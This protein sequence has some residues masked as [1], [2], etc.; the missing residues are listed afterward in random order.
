MRNSTLARAIAWTLALLLLPDVAAAREPAAPTTS[1]EQNGFVLRSA[2]GA[3]S[4]RLLGLLQIQLAHEQTAGSPG[5]G[6]LFVNRARAGLLG[7]I[8]SRDLRYTL[9]AEFSGKSPRLMFLNVDYTFVPD[10]LSLR[11]GQFKR[12]FSRPFMTLASELSMIDRPSPVGPAVFGDNADIGVMLHNGTTGRLEYA[13]GIFNGA[14]PNVLP[15][16]VHP[17]IAARVAYSTKGSMP[18]SESDLDGG[19]PRFGVAAAG[20]VD[21]DGDRDH[22]SFTSG[23]VD[24]MF[25]AR[26]LTLTS[27]LY[28]GSRQAGPRWTDQRFN[29]L[30]HYT[31]IGY[32]IARRFEPVVR[33]SF[34]RPEGAGNDQHDVTGG[35]NVFFRGHAFKWQTFVSARFQQP[36]GE[37]APD[38]R[39]QSQLSLAF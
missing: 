31:Q 4:L 21:L 33:H 12:P 11:V 20:L 24:V 16:R 27:A 19:A 32:V 23:L 18:Y 8:F 15:D 9:V 30:G 7:S 13:V 17:L 5:K 3:N 10:R 25:K 26:G 38:M 34:V 37:T 22:A 28:A 2:D 35:L 29:A 1:P 6:A 39:L 36:D 14:G